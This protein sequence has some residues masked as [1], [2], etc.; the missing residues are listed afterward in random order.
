MPGTVFGGGPA[1]PGGAG[2]REMTE[3]CQ[4]CAK[5]ATYHITDI[6]KGRPREFHFC[7][8]HARQHLA[9]SDEPSG[10]PIGDLAEALSKTGTATGREP[11]P[12]DRRSCPICQ[13]T[14][15]EFRNSGRLGCPHDY[16]VFLDELMPLLENIHDETR[17]CGKV[18]Q[19]APR[20]S[21][22]QTELIDLR[23]KLKRAV[24]AEDYEAAATIRDQ[25]KT[26]ESEQHR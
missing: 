14:F 19:R 4:K 3:K 5:K 22:R 12:A 18:P 24:A 23:N 16:E 20:T 15:L 9:P 26:I 1:R 2:D 6:E 7:D 13:L 11:S 25:I 17:H 8:E 21:Q 10:T